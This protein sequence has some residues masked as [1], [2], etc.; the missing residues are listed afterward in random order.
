MSSHAKVPIGYS[1]NAETWATLKNQ[2]DGK[3][4]S[5]QE[6]GG[7]IGSMFGLYATSSG[8]PTTNSA[9]F[10]WLKYEGNDPAHRK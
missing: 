9:A 6:V 8:K 10:K 2:V 1:E 4:L 7:F 5:T 3:F